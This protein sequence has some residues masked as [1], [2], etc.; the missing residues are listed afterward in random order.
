MTLAVMLTILLAQAA[1]SPSPTGSACFQEATVLKP[2][3]PD[4]PSSAMEYAP[5]YAYVAVLL[6]ADGS[7]EKVVVLKSSGYG[8]FDLAAVRAAQHSTYRPR[9]ANCKPI[10]GGYVFEASLTQGP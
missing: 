3:R 8:P 1:P 9:I 4:P 5:L 6:A 7:V 2:E 10:E